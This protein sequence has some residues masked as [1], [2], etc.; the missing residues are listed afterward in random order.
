MKVYRVLVLRRAFIVAQGVKMRKIRFIIHDMKLLTR[1]VIP[2]MLSMITAGI[3]TVV[4]GLFVGWGAGSQG[5][6]ALNVAYPMALLLIAIGEMIGIGGAINI[7]IARGRQHTRVTGN[8]LNTML[9][10]AIPVAIILPLVILPFLSTL[11]SWMGAAPELMKDAWM[12]AAIIIGAGIFQIT[13]IALLEAIRNDNSPHRAMFILIAGLIINIILDYWFVILLKGGVAGSAWATVTAQ[14]FC[15][16]LALFYFNSKHTTMRIKL[17][18]LR[19]R[20]VILW[21]TIIAG[22]PSFG[23]QISIALVIWLHNS[24]ALRYGGVNAV[25]A[26]AVISY[27]EASILLMIQGIALGLQPVVSFLHGAGK[28]MRRKR[29]AFYGM[30]ISIAFGLLSTLITITGGRFLA[31]AFNAQGQV[32]ELAVIG[33]CIMSPM[34]PLA[35]FQKIS[36]SYF[37]SMSRPG[38]AS[39][40]IYLDSCVILPMCLF[41]LPVYGGLKGVWAALPLTKLIIFFVTLWLWRRNEGAL[42]D[43]E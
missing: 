9:A 11:L 31:M 13:V 36:E 7:S 30:G 12:Y 18:K 21:R 19:M 10:V 14:A 25:A 39:L 22:I 41:I 17:H 1:F 28:F 33:L 5:M 34:Y 40:L 15:L 8:I 2:S 27:I 43:G 6:A 24:Q 42:D 23:V 35:G 29:M 20:K 38:A 3:Y 37:Q 4:D 16:T 26:Y 32:L